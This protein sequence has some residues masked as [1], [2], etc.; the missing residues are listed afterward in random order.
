MKLVVGR[1]YKV[2]SHPYRWMSRFNQL[3]PHKCEPRRNWVSAGTFAF[4]GAFY[5]AAGE[6]VLGG[7]P[8]QEIPTLE[9]VLYGIPIDD[10]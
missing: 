2:D 8:L 4:G 1:W 9:R 6:F 7:Y 5:T 10:A 3:T